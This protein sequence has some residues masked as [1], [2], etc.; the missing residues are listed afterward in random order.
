MNQERIINQYTKETVWSVYAKR[1]DFFKLA[2]KYGID[3]VI[4]RIIRNRDIITEDGIDMYLN[5]DISNTHEPSLMK[6]MEKGCR[7]MKQKLGEGSHVRIISDYDVDGVMSAYILYKGL[8]KAANEIYNDFPIID[9]D[10]PHRMRDGYGINIR[11]VDKAYE[12]G[13][14]TIITCDNGIAAF[15]AIL[16]AKEHGM[17]VIITDHHD[18]PYTIDEAGNRCYNIPDADAVIDHKQK[19]C[20]YPFKEICGAGVAYKFIQYLYR[21]CG[22]DESKCQEFIEYL[23]IATV[24]DVMNLIDENR[25]FVRAALN[26]LK[27]SSNYGLAALIRNSGREGKKL[28]SYDLGFIIGPCINAAG[29]LGDAKLCM[30]FLLEEDS[31]KADSLSLELINVNNERKDMTV[32]ATTQSMQML[33]DNTCRL[34][35]GE[36]LDD[37]VPTL[38]DKVI[39]LYLPNVHESL[40][41]IIAGRVK[42]RF[43]RPV[44]LFTDSE[45]KD[46][47]KGSGRSIAGYSMYDELNKANHMFI[48]FGGHD[49]AAG[50]SIKRE[51]LGSL[52]RELNS[53]A[54]LDDKQLTPKLMIDVP[55]PLSYNSISLTRQLNLI[56]PFGKGNEKP[57]FAQSG[58]R[59]R[60]AIIMGRNKNVLRLTLEMDNNETITG[61]NFDPDTFISRIKEWFGESECDKILKGLTDKVILDIAYYPDINEYQG[62]EELQIRILEYRKHND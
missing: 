34:H 53:R 61:M 40:V 60:R 10:I 50:F 52:R 32:K 30:D 16:R 28:T 39:V 58:V 42:E 46:I 22:I 45:D 18:I 13:V 25:V 8:I 31:Y 6:D 3:P 59:V 56:E 23:G 2:D 4:A 54:E 38:A 57:V 47:L 62:S 5:G 24:C 15:D 35:N 12:D 33:I 14:D 48:K 36:T 26:K 9:Y 27:K 21:I 49:M 7:I 29:R 44:L 20:G 37:T 17:T 41:G 51:M 19:D 11:L 55:M 43:Y 1:A